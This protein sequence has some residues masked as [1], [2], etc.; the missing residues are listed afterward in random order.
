MSNKIKKQFSNPLFDGADPWIINYN[1]NYYYCGSEDDLGIY[2]ME[3]SDPTFTDS[4][5]VTVW[6]APETGWNSKEVWA[7]EL[8][9]I[10]DK[11]Y[12]YYA[13]DDGYNANHRMGVLKA[14]GSNPM[15]GFEDLGQ[16][17]TGGRWAIDG[18]PLL[19]DNALYMVWSGW[20]GKGD[21]IQNLYIASMK[22]P[23]TIDGEP[24]L[25]STPELDWEKSEFPI[26]EGPQILVKGDTVHIVFS[27]NASWTEK[28]CQGLLTLE[29]GGDPLLPSSWIKKDTP[30]FKGNH[31]V[32]GV[33]HVSFFSDVEGNEW[34]AYH[35][36]KD[37]KHGWDRDI[38]IQQFSW[39][40]NIPVFGDALSTN[41]KFEITIEE[42]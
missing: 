35:S 39:N 34:I 29:T 37:L 26:H 7:P 5:K 4:K 6:K 9:M 8:H 1:N 17:Y 16:L 2:L 3:S 32:Y 41:I 12:I 19:V 31:S 14:K 42:K 10:N 27:A 36:K 11:W 15:D 38:R 18:T 13:A 23:E 30:I 20:P 28:Y 33:G 22:D 25:I 40:K 24:V 21:S